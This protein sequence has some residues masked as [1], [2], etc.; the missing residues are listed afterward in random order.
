VRFTKRRESLDKLLRTL[1]VEGEGQGQKWDNS[2]LNDSRLRLFS[3]SRP[4]RDREKG[5]RGGLK[6]RGAEF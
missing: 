3:V 5:R 6:D 1:E 2:E 4:R